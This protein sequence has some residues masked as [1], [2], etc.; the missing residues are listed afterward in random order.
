[1]GEFLESFVGVEGLKE[2]ISLCLTLDNY[3]RVAATV[4]QE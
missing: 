1:M 2:I 3:D 4:A